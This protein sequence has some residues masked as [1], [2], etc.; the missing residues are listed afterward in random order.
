MPFTD[1]TSSISRIFKHICHSILFRA[2]NHTG[3]SCCH[4]GIRTTPCI[5]TG[6]QRVTGRGTGSSYGVSIGKANTFTRQTIDIGSLHILC[7]ITF[8][9]TITQVI[10]QNN[11]HI[12]LL[13]IGHFILFG[14]PGFRSQSRT[15][16]RCQER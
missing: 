8:Q 9:I 1:C 3:I 5:F 6:Q 16:H 15:Q 13:T 12:G 10:S 11:N 7:T 4:I 14:S 2:D